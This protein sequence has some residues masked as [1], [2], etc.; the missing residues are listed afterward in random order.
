MAEIAALLGDAKKVGSLLLGGRGRLSSAAHRRKAIELITEAHAAGAGLVSACDE[1]GI[2]L[3]VSWSSPQP[4]AL[5]RMRT[6]VQSGSIPIAKLNVNHAS[7]K[8]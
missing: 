6:I 1:I 4:A 8:N 5:S 2:W 7:S 3:S